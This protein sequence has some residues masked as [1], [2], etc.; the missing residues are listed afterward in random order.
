MENSFTLPAKFAEIRVKGKTAFVPSVEIDG[1]TII[2]TGKFFKLAMIRDG[3]VAEGELVK[4]PETFVAILKNSQLKA[5]VFTFFQ[6]PPDVTPRFNF[7]FDWDNYAAVPISTFENWWENLPQE[8]R[9]NVRRAAKRGVVVKTVPFDDE[10]ARGI[11][12]LCNESPVRQGKPFWHFGKD[13]ETVKREHST[14]LE[15][16]EFIGAFFQDELIGFIKMVHVDS[17]A[18]IF[19]ILAA[20]AHYDKR[21]INALIAK[22]VE[23]CAQKETGY[24]VYD[25]NV[26]GNKSDSSLVEF[27]RRNGF[28]QINF[29]RFYIPLTLTGKIFVALKLYRG[30]VGILPAPVLKMILAVREWIYAQK[31]T[32]KSSI[33]PS[34]Q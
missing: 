8:T 30:L 20:N 17:V 27:K 6:R 1:R 24:F 23:V 22:A 29:P 10:L 2:A 28:E 7:H 11:H 21:P 34:I 12:K 13:F 3:D 32:I 14:Y 4:N 15:R 19:H 31:T 18:F 16:S 5:D 33:N 25:K 26:Y 9:K